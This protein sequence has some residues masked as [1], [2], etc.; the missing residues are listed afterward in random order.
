[1]SGF[2]RL[3]RPALPLLKGESMS[4][5]YQINATYR[6]D[7][8]RLNYILQKKY[9][10][11]AE[12]KAETWVTIGFYQTVKQLYHALVELGIK[13][14]SLAAVKD[15]NAKVEELHILITSMPNFKEKG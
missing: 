15:L 13:E 2:N 3:P 12:S 5:I 14:A 1:M 10:K 4:E 11:K 8:D 7:Q 9:K 6:I